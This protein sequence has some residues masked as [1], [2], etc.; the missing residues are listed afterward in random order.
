[1]HYL[2]GYSR[3]AAAT[4]IAATH[5]VQVAPGQADIAQKAW[6]EGLRRQVIQPDLAFAFLAR[7]RLEDVAGLTTSTDE[8]ADS[9]MQ[10][11]HIQRDTVF[12]NL[13]NWAN[14]SDREAFY[15]D[16]HH[17]ALHRYLSSVGTVH[18]LQLEPM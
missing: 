12:L 5:L 13:L 8:N 1:M 15:A 10:G 14:E 16:A 2:W 11:L 4:T 3:P 6:I 17:Q 9:V 18:I 7:G